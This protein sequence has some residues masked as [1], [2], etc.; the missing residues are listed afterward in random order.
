MF[1]RGEGGEGA[2]AESRAMAGR[3]RGYG[4][5]MA[6]QLLAAESLRDSEAS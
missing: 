1:G 5:A 3:L 2:G 4:G 6:G